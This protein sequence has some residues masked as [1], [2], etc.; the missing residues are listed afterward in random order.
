MKNHLLFLVGDTILFV[1][2]KTYLGGEY[3]SPVK[4]EN[5]NEYNQLE[6]ER[7]VCLTF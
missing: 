6:E 2:L 3:N 7:Y 4:K 5:K 1:T